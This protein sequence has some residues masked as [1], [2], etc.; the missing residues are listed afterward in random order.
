MNLDDHIGIFVRNA[1]LSISSYVKKQL[2][3]FNLAPEQTL[4]MMMLWKKNGIYP[5]EL[6]TELNKDK[7][8]IARMIVSLEK[9]G[10]IIREDDPSDKRTFKVYLTKEGKHLESLVVP[11][12]R[13]TNNTVINGI[14]EEK[15]V[16]MQNLISKMINNSIE[17]NK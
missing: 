17:G 4:I 6:S 5:N 1:H 11:V 8:N 15:L 10:Y 7:A 13:K 3:P 9:K 12:L 16:D 14:P 2:E